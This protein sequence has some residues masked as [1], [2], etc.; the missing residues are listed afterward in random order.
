MPG[1]QLQNLIPIERR[2]FQVTRTSPIGTT[3]SVN[4]AVVFFDTTPV[5]KWGAAYPIGS[6]AVAPT[7]GSG[8]WCNVISDAQFGT[9]LKFTRR[10]FYEV[11]VSTSIPLTAETFP[12]VGQALI[13]DSSAASLLAGAALLPTTTNAFGA[14]GVIDW[15][16]D[17]QSTQAKS[18]KLG[19]TVPITDAQAGGAQPTAA[20]GAQGV[21][22][23]RLHMNNNAGG[24]FSPAAIIMSMWVNYHNDI[25]G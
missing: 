20:V 15:L 17:Q 22:C 10:G 25:A 21:G 13:L 14:P 16:T 1:G 3:G 7:S 19:G 11:H 6:T 9:V 8:T 2:S 23:V 18:L 4:T 5:L 24:A 12:L